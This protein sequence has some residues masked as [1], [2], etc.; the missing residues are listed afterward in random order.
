MTS[1]IDPTKPVSGT[2]TTASVRANFAA[3]AEEISAIQAVVAGA[4]RVRTVQLDIASN[5]II[6]NDAELAFP[7]DANSIYIARYTMR[8]GPT[9]ATTGFKAAVTVPAG[10]VLEVVTG[11]IQSVI[12]A[13]NT[14]VKFT[15]TS[16]GAM[17]FLAASQVAVGSGMVIIDAYIATGPTAGTVEIGFAQGTSSVV[18]LSIFAGARC[19]A[20]KVQ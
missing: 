7:V 20:N 13:A 16:G 6:A 10:A 11:I 8:V 3:A 5:I 17:T 9:L 18:N 14:A 19:I 12:T 4:T 1:A 15:S 2:P